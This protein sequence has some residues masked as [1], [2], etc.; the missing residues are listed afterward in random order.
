MRR[1]HPLAGADSSRM[2]LPPDRCHCMVRLVRDP[3]Y[4]H[5]LDETFQSLEK[6][7]RSVLV[8]NLY[9]NSESPIE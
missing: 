1:H 6:R 5:I 7:E 3:W 8:S 4:C 9:G 2:L